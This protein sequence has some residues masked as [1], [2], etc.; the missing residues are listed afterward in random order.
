MSA[1]I[2]LER[3]EIIARSH[4]CENCGEYSY[5]K[6]SVKPASD[7]HR[8]EFNEVWHAVKICGVCGLHQEMGIDEDGDIVYVG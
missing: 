5:K 1:A 8:R 6:L 4:A 3:A 7:A 2:T